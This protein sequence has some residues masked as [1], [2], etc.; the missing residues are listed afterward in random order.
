[1][2]RRECPVTGQTGLSDFRN[3]AA[4]SREWLIM[5]MLIIRGFAGLDIRH[6]DVRAGLL[7]DRLGLGHLPHGA[8][9]RADTDLVLRNVEDADVRFAPLVGVD[10]SELDVRVSA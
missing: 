5:D 3:S 4:R 6:D 2:E 9:R 1:M 10:W 8:P 7:A